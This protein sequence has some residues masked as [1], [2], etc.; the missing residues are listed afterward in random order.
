M[1]RLLCSP[2]AEKS[3]PLGKC[4]PFQSMLTHVTLHWLLCGPTAKKSDPSEKR[5]TILKHVNP[6]YTL[7]SNLAQCLIRHHWSVM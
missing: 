4:K 5:R 6:H 1:H 3:D 7:V 2:T